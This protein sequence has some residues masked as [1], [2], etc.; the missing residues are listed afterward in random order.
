MFLLKYQ[1]NPKSQK[2]LNKEWGTSLRRGRIRRTSP[3]RVVTMMLLP[4]AS[5]TS[6]LSVLR[7]SQGRAVKLYGLEVSA[8]TGHK[9]IMFPD[10]SDRNIF[11]TYVPTYWQSIH[12]VY[13]NF[14]VQLELGSMKQSCFLKSLSASF[15]VSFCSYSALVSKYGKDLLGQLWFTK[16]SFRKK[17]KSCIVSVNC[18]VSPYTAG[19]T[20]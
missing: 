20:S 16:I 15:L 3:V 18:L 1:L 2:N 19:D 14:L 8:P 6:T 7:V 17:L 4:T 10:S 5:W 9:S 13:K 12:L 11:S